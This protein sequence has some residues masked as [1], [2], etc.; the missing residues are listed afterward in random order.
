MKRLYCLMS[1][2]LLSNWYCSAAVIIR[3][4]S[5]LP[6]FGF[7]AD[8]N[9]FAFDPLSGAIYV[10]LA[11]N[12]DGTIDQFAISTAIRP[13]FSSTPVFRGIATNQSLT[14]DQPISLLSISS[15]INLDPLA[16][17][18]RQNTNSN[19]VAVSNRVVTTPEGTVNITA[20]SPTLNDA[21]GISTISDIISLASS[22]NFIFAA[23]PESGAQFGQVGTNSGISLLQINRSLSGL[24]L[25]TLNSPIGTAGNAASLLNADSPVITGG[26][27]PV[28]FLGGSDADKVALFFDPVLNLLYT[29]LRVETGDM[30]GDIAKAVVIGEVT[31]NNALMFREIVPN[32][33]LDIFDRIV[34]AQAGS[35][36]PSLSIKNLAVLHA[37]TG[38]DYLIVNGGQG[39]TATVGNKVF[40]LPLVN[41]PGTPEHG[42]LADKNSP[43]DPIRHVFVTPATTS[44]GLVSTSDPAALVGGGNVPIEAS[45]SISALRAVGDTVY[46]SSA[47]PNNMLNNSGIFFSRALFDPSGKIARWTPWAQILPQNLFFGNVPNSGLISNFAVDART[48]L[49]SFVEGGRNVGITNFTTNNGNQGLITA[50]NRILPNGVFSVLDLNQSTR[51]FTDASTAGFRYALF[52]GAN[53]VSFALISRSTDVTNPNAPQIFTTDFTL[54]QNFLTTFLP[55]NAGCVTALEFSRQTSAEGNQNFFFAGTETGLF[56]FAQ[57]NGEGFSVN[58]LMMLDQPPFTTGQWQRVSTINGPITQLRTSGNRLYILA[59]T[60]TPQNPLQSTLYSVP[61]TSNVQTMFANP[62]VI[63]QTG[64][65]PFENVLQFFDIALLATGPTDNPTLHEQLVLATN[66]GL[67]FSSNPN[68][69]QT[70]TNALSA[71]WQLLEGTGQMLFNGI[72]Q[73]TTQPQFTVWPF[74]LADLSG[75]RTFT[76]SM[77]FQLTSGS[78][79]T[80]P[81]INFVPVLF[82]AQDP[83]LFPTFDHIFGFWSDGT[84]RFLITQPAS[85]ST[86]SMNL[87]IL[88]FNTQEWNAQN[89]L[90]LQFGPLSTLSQFYWVQSIGAS[91][92]VLSGTNTGVVGIA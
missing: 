5:T 90:P 71:N 9:A 46:V 55:P 67:F 25:S 68:G 80:T 57:P 72:G 20:E 63:A 13:S 50:L 27:S 76:Q 77:L 51:G 30:M 12:A 78:D 66:Q 11:Q 45:N 19:I 65:T 18:V 4:N 16:I 74:S 60:G 70:A 35:I 14:F 53:S 49:I 41:N 47:N 21:S 79:A 89:L 17:A 24:S 39:T 69:V 81:F 54:P 31:A 23:V 7:N 28:T 86:A 91:G 10:G 26:T 37:S 83:A 34:A 92:L 87:A 52:G 6:P 33:A 59:Q 1:L 32:S 38:P 84:R 40:A 85:S 62:T 29:G 88:P 15:G 64:A 36:I 3:G 42:M 8:I 56:V 22:P 73:D 82:N 75:R 44:S 43:L 61:F 2:L 48:G 58:D